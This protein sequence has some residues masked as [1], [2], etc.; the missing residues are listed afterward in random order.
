[1][2]T[3][4]TA[5]Q[6]GSQ[7]IKNFDLTKLFLGSNRF[8]S[9]TYT[10]NTGSEVT[11]AAGTLLGKVTKADTNTAGHLLPHSA[12]DTEGANIPVGI[13]A[14]TVTVADGEAV[15]LQYA[16]GGDFDVSLLTLNGSET[17]DTLVTISTDGTDPDNVMAIRE[18]IIAYTTLNPV[19]VEELSAT[20]NQ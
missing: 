3:E 17:L 18:L 12:G 6:T 4:S 16:D 10:N 9:A 1:M 15:N 20:D 11:I 7:L 14:R 5:L 13:A 19:V 2:S 8:K